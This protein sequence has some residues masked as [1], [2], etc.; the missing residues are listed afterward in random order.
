MRYF[1]SYNYKT[2]DNCDGFGSAEVNFRKRIDSYDDIKEISN[3]ICDEF[4]FTNVVIL[5]YK[6]F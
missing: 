4:G 2:K 1:V 5:N 6:R 3:D